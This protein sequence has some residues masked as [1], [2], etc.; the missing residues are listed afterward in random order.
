MTKQNG[1]NI[2]ILLLSESL[3]AMLHTRQHEL[4]GYISQAVNSITIDAGEKILATMGEMMT[5]EISK[6]FA[7][8]FTT[9]AGRQ[10]I[11][12]NVQATLR[13]FMP[14]IDLLEQSDNGE[15]EP[16]ILKR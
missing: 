16:L 10:V 11:E 2:P 7:E 4:D 12:S 9:G 15:D 14:T 13:R 3:E 1:F 8:Y 6:R 5:K